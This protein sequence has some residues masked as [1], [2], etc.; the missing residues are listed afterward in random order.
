[1]TK[2]RNEAFITRQSLI[3]ALKDGQRWPEF[4]EIYRK[5][6]YGYARK[7]GLSH[8]EAE[9]VVQEAMT[10][11]WK[12]IS[13]FDRTRGRFK[14]WLLKMTRWRVIDQFR[15]RGPLVPLPPWADDPTTGDGAMEP[16][17][18]QFDAWWE[19]EWEKNLHDAAAAIVKRRAEPQQ[20]QIFD[21]Y[22]NKGWPPEKV[23]ATF[24]VPVEK[25]YR[26]KHRV[27][28]MFEAAAKV[29]KKNW[30]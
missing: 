9:D 12:H 2:Y 16:A 15:K 8:A 22:V 20:Y 18:D 3:D 19:S 5:L 28:R 23:A 17:A 25:V 7:E 13:E 14:S 10:S 4:Y 27:K 24:G 11:V 6:I 26:D 21:F 30:T 29:L 1:M